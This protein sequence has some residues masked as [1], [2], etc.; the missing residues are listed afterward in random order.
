MDGKGRS[1]ASVL[2]WQEA[3]GSP[4]LG[5]LVSLQSLCRWPLPQPT[6]G[7]PHPHRQARVTRPGHQGH[8]GPITAPQFPEPSCNSGPG[9]RSPWQAGA[10]EGIRGTSPDAPPRV[11]I[12]SRC[13]TGT[14]PAGIA[15][16]LP[17]L[18][19]TVSGSW[20]AGLGLREAEACRAQTTCAVWRQC[21]TGVVGPA[22]SL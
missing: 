18:D 19:L 22:I 21:R 13:G 2:G 14:C 3:A 15:S 7:F 6:R 16:V 1:P 11:G 12:F 5:T 9:R 10:R 17:V 4:A 8:G 20:G